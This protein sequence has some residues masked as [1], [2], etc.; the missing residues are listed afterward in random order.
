MNMH[1]VIVGMLK[2]VDTGV[3][4]RGWSVADALQ[5]GCAWTEEVINRLTGVKP[6]DLIQRPPVT[7]PRGPNKPPGKPG[8]SSAIDAIMRTFAEAG[9][10]VGGSGVADTKAEEPVRKL[11]K[12]GT[13]KQCDATMR[14]FFPKFEAGKVPTLDVEIEA[15]EAWC[16][17]RDKKIAN[18]TG[19]AGPTD[20]AAKVDS[21]NH[22]PLD[23]V[24]PIG[25][26]VTAEEAMRDYDPDGLLQQPT[27]KTRA[28]V[29]AEGGEG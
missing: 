5:F 3:Q 25:Q 1:E 26:V 13:C 17:E 27:P 8:P 6:V 10:T 19:K 24:V 12:F 22:G 11:C 4:H 29:A 15:F 7:P 16:N 2:V 18:Q 28:D 23:D 14:A 9:F 20:A 21:R